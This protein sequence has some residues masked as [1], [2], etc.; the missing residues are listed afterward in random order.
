M[1]RLIIIFITVT[2]L[3]LSGC[4]GGEQ[5]AAPGTAASPADTPAPEQTSPD[6]AS[7]PASQPTEAP[8]SGTQPAETEPDTIILPG[9]E[10]LGLLS[11]IP[12]YSVYVGYENYRPES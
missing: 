2:A 10:D 12:V 1:K 11:E 6:A 5:T 7:E 8:G 3:I 9:K 4:A